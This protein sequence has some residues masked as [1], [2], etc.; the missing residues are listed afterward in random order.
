MHVVALKEPY[1]EILRID[2]IITC[3][4]CPQMRSFNELMRD[5]I[6]VLLDDPR[7][8]VDTGEAVR[9]YE[10]VLRRRHGDAYI[11]ELNSTI[12]TTPEL[13]SLDSDTRAIIAIPVWWV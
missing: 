7:S 13:H 9:W 6:P 5:T 11:D 10:G 3:T 1:Q 4:A 8:M 2:I 12:D